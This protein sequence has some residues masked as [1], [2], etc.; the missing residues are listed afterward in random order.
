MARISSASVPEQGTSFASAT[1]MARGNPYLSPDLA[2][3]FCDRLSFLSPREQEI[4][5]LVANGMANKEIG[6]ALGISHWTVSAHLR[7]I[8]LKLEID[9]RIDLCLLYRAM[10][11][12]GECT[13][14]GLSR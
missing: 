14:T 4:A 7:R 10:I 13:S 9:R 12:R 3:R 11:S 8:F 1:P 2:S 5:R 6:L